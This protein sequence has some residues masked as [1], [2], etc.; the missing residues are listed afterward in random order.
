[1]VFFFAIT[2]IKFSFVA[3]RTLKEHGYEVVTFE[4]SNKIGGIWS[5][6]YPGAKLQNSGNEYYF[7]E[8]PPTKHYK[9]FHPTAE[10]VLAYLQVRFCLNFRPDIRKD[11]AEHFKLTENIRFCHEVTNLELLPSKK[12]VVKSCNTNTRQSHDDEIFDY[13]IIAKGQVR[14]KL[15]SFNK[16]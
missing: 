11:Y 3:T 6:A 14:Q 1:M 8:Y 15:L 16:F 9:N 12:W 5:V 13:V 7:P 2:K 4:K 10:E